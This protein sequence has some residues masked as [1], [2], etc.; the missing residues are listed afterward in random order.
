MAE[1]ATL[2][3]NICGQIHTQAVSPVTGEPITFGGIRLFTCEAIPAGQ[4][5]F[6]IML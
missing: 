4:F 5:P 2:D 1:L 6:G 3:C